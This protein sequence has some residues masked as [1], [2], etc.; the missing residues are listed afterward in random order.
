MMMKIAVFEPHTRL[1]GVTKWTFDVAAGFRDLG[2]ECDVVS[3]TKSGKARKSGE[4]RF[5]GWYWWHEEPSRMGTW[6][7]AGKILDEYDLIVLNEPKNGTEDREAIRYGIDPW[8]IGALR[9]TKTPWMT[10]LHAPQYDSKRAP[11]LVNCL[12]A[13]NFTGFVVSRTGGTAGHAHGRRHA[14]ARGCCSGARAGRRGACRSGPAADTGR[15][16]D[17]GLGSDRRR[18]GRTGVRTGS[19]RCSGA[20]CACRAAADRGFGGPSGAGACRAAVASAGG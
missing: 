9:R 20:G 1:C 15:C 7:Q 11:Y 8:Y 16:R 2:H 5:N 18:A 6:L 4:K 13:G 10:I 19:C 14:A 17:A 3:F 12:E